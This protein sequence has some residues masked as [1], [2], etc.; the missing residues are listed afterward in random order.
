MSPALQRHAREEARRRREKLLRVIVEGGGGRP[1]IR[2]GRRPR[3][4]LAQCLRLLLT[5]AAI[6]A[7]LSVSYE[8]FF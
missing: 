2:S 6:L 3:E 7:I 1:R 5:A 8:F 4:F